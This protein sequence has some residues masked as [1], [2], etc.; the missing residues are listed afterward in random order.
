MKVGDYVR[1]KDGKIGKII[2]EEYITPCND[3]HE[4]IYLTDADNEMWYDE[5]TI[6]K[7]SPKPIG[8]IKVGDYV[9]GCYVDEIIGANDSWDDRQHFHLLKFNS[10]F[11]NSD[12]KSIV[13]HEQ[14]SQMEYKVGE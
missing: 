4:Y 10:Y 11:G 8:L 2:Q 14:F 9:N 7:S 6:I 13:T 1:T 12:I 5:D 3:K